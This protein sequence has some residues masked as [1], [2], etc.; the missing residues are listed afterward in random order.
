MREDERGSVQGRERKEVKY[1]VHRCGR[2]RLEHYL[3][4]R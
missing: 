4:Q 1:R 2:E 3:H